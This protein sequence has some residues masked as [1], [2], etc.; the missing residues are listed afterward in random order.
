MNTAQLREY[1]EDA[2]ALEKLVFYQQWL[3]LQWEGERAALRRKLWDSSPGRPPKGPENPLPGVLT[4]LLLAFVLVVAAAAGIGIL[5]FG[6]VRGS[7]IGTLG[8]ILLG[9]IVVVGAYFLYGKRAVEAWSASGDRQERAAD[10]ERAKQA[11]EEKAQAYPLKKTLPSLRMEVLNEAI[12][13]AEDKRQASQEALAALYAQDVI[14]PKYRGLLALCSL[15]EYL[16]TGRCDK[17]EGPNGAYAL[18][19]AELAQKKIALDLIDYDPKTAR[20]MQ[21]EAYSVFQELSDQAAAMSAE[22]DRRVKERLRG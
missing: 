9:V 16:Q 17:L 19:E 18:L 20:A 7:L 4:K 12:Q 6:P 14:F 8:G 5:L 3:V 13:E 22:I 15:H 1:L 10:D 2:I 21:F 11:Y